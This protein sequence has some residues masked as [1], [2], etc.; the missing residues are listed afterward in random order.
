MDARLER[1]ARNER[2][3]RRANERIGSVSEDLSE[4]GFAREHDEVEFLC[5]CGRAVCPATL[6]LTVGEYEAAHEPGR[7]FLIAPGHETPTIERVVE[8]HEDYS[9]VEKRPE[10]V[11]EAFDDPRWRGEEV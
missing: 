8:R 1:I 4:Q 11:A 3:L 5:E 7:R 2:W 9:V 6:T 10:V